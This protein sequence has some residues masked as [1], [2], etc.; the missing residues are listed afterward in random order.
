[1]IIV[2]EGDYLRLRREAKWHRVVDIK[3][4]DICVLDDGR[5]VVALD[6][7]DGGIVA[8]VLSEREY[9]LGDVE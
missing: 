3:P 6:V 5:Q 2:F 8:E 4:F 9:K 1:M 7:K